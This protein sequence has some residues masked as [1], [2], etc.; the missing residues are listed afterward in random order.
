M[1]NSRVLKLHRQTGLKCKLSTFN[2]LCYYW[3]Y[4]LSFPRG[5]FCFPVHWYGLVMWPALANEIRGQVRQ[6]P[7]SRPF[8]SHRLLLL[9]ALFSVFWWLAKSLIEG[10]LWGSVRVL[11]WRQDRL[12]KSHTWITW[13]ISIS[14]KQTF[15][16]VS[17]WDT[18]D[19]VTAV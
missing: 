16:N 4:L 6:A 15:V 9:C 11:G 10:A 17:H 14:K 7:V 19:A 5:R 8:R 12:E 1:H 2:G 3:K 13:F 18:E